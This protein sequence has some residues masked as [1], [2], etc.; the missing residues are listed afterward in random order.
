MGQGAN[1]VPP[2]MNPMTSAMS[3]SASMQDA[4]RRSTEERLRMELA[5]RD[6]LA[7]RFRSDLAEEEARFQA[8]IN[9]RTAAEIHGAN[10]AQVVR[11]RNQEIIRQAEV[12]RQ[13][14]LSSL[15]GRISSGSITPSQATDEAA[16][17]NRRYAESTR[18]ASSAL[19]LL[20]VAHD[21]T[22]RNM[23]VRSAELIGIYGVLH[24][25]FTQLWEAAKAIP[26]IGIELDTTKASLEA[27]M[28]GAIS[29]ANAISAINKEA[30][31]T[32][33]SLN[34]LRENFRNFQASTSLAGASLNSTWN[35]FTNLN[36][37]I[38]GLHLNADKANGVFLAMAQIFNK[39]KVQSEE[40]VKQLGNLLPG[41]FASFADSMGITTQELAKRMK[42]G[43]VFAKD[44]MEE[45]LQYMKNKFAPAFAA[46]SEGLNANIGRMETSF[47]HLGE[48]IYTKISP[49]LIDMT[50][51]IAN[52]VDSVTEFVK[53]MDNL[54]NAVIPVVA[55][56]I[57]GITAAFAKFV[58]QIVLVR[59]SFGSVMAG[60]EATAI[61]VGALTS[62]AAL[63]QVGTA[64]VTSAMVGLRAAM[65]FIISPV[66]IIAGIAAITYA[67][68]SWETAE[69][70]L[71]KIHNR[72]IDRNKEIDRIRSQ[73]SKPMTEAESLNLSVMASPAVVEDKRTYDEAKASA[74]KAMR[75]RDL[76]IKFFGNDEA[77]RK[78]L[79]EKGIEDANKVEFARITLQR[80][81]NLE[82]EKLLEERQKAALNAKKEEED[83]H[84]EALAEAKA[85]ADKEAKTLEDAVA[86]A[87]E[88]YA[89][90]TKKNREYWQGLRDTS[91]KEQARLIQAEKKGVPLENAADRM[92]KVKK[93]IADANEATNYLNEGL[94]ETVQKTK[95]EWQKKID[96]A[97]K[98]STK[99][100]RAV[101]EDFN[102]DGKIAAMQ[103][104]AYLEQIKEKYQEG[105]LSVKEYYAIRRKA[106]QDDLVEQQKQQI[107]ILKL[108]M[109]QKTL[110]LLRNIAMKKLVSQRKQI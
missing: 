72:L 80:T 69:E 45:F 83:T 53:T 4:Y 7:S 51:K 66:G 2:S 40:L 100:M 68:S 33:I 36:T 16:E 25:S 15:P 85:F 108:L 93:D 38:T 58:A 75:E 64:A 94:A 32:G 50:K 61:T 105:S 24:S 89:E 63:L 59:A 29:A 17:A 78:V 28:G 96:K 86:Y 91:E 82:T 11:V 8:S 52:T 39:G 76:Y 62:R 102:R 19:A 90:R 42:A 6:V 44:T 106:I 47:I 81:I 35:M 13:N 26:K 84:S 99:G 27:T 60:A 43:Q 5:Q 37:I 20:D 46:A 98:T 74:E 95:D 77:K 10:S 87:T 97:S 9:L 48:A 92:A 88:K 55:V 103:N 18:Q 73:G 49:T 109:V 107:L 56:A 23:L 31:R 79:V 110:T 30:S 12:A 22:F 65:G 101:Y 104:D 57:F 34:V 3:I 71:E 14:V 21:R 41:A 67:I 1:V 54:S 70:K